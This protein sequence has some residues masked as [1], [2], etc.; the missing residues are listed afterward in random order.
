MFNYNFFPD[1]PMK[2]DIFCIS[3]RFCFALF[4]E[5]FITGELELKVSLVL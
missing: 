4:E 1:P 2:F 3:G 5:L